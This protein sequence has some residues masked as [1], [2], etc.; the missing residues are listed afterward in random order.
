MPT[1][2]RI[3]HMFYF[4]NEVELTPCTAIA[5]SIGD[6]VRQPA[7]FIHYCDKMF[8]DWDGVI[9][10]YDMPKTDEEASEMLLE[11]DEDQDWETLETVIFPDGTTLSD[12]VEC[13]P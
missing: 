5:A 7:I 8:A 9:F 4:M 6:T 10:G 13:H 2:F 1:R 3:N 12:Y 11:C